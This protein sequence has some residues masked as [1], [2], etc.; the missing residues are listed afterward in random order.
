MASTQFNPAQ[1]PSYCSVGPEADL[2]SSALIQWLR[3][4]FQTL[5]NIEDPI[6]AEQN[7][8]FLW[9]P[10]ITTSNIVIESIGKFDASTIEQ[11]PAL[12]IK[13]NGFQTQRQGI[14]NLLMGYN[15]KDAAQGYT[16]FWTGSHTVLC[17]AGE[18]LECEKLAREV[19]R[20]L[21]QFAPRMR[22]IL[23]LNRLQIAE[24]GEVSLVEESS[25]HFVVPVSIASAFEESWLLR[26][27]SPVLKAINW[28]VNVD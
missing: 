19:K 21:G 7:T 5:S 9:T 25:Q 8:S 13:R 2:I 26:P 12:F 15:R 28:Y 10:D 20:E 16:I 22:A 1:I 4:H 23:N 11:R 27:L 17:M 18:Y 6:L 14:A 24:L 3:A